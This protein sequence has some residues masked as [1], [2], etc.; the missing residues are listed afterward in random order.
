[1]SDVEFNQAEREI[2]PTKSLAKQIREIGVTKE[3]KW[4]P[5]KIGFRDVTQQEAE[6]AKSFLPKVIL[7]GLSLKSEINSDAWGGILF[8]IAASKDDNERCITYIYNWTKQKGTLSFWFA[9]APALLLSFLALVIL[10]TTNNVLM[11]TTAI[12]VGLFMIIAGLKPYI[13]AIVTKRERVL[14]IHNE[15]WLIFYGVIFIVTIPLEWNVHIIYGGVPAMPF[16]FLAIGLL[17]LFLRLFE[18][19]L[20]LGT[21]EMD[22]EPVFVYL[23]REGE[24]WVISK[25][26]F[27]RFHYIVQTT[28]REELI[29]NNYLIKTKDGERVQ[30]IIDNNWHS[31]RLTNKDYHTLTSMALVIFYIFLGDFIILAISFLFGS[32]FSV[33]ALLIGEAA[34][35]VDPL[36]FWVSGLLYYAIH[37]FELELKDFDPHHPKYHL[38]DRKLDVLWNLNEEE[39]RLIMR[40]KIQDPFNK[41]TLFWSTFRDDALSVLLF[42]VL[43]RLDKIEDYLKKHSDGKYE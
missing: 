22:Y 24:K 3:E 19:K 33:V 5:K 23:K 12:T 29:K 40:L 8:R 27:D 25:V 4:R 13:Q 37:P 2:W 36:V 41:E 26:R 30:L 42:N 1:M 9:V 21:H 17:I 34:I 43:P 15:T 39:A 16:V 20:G 38:T 11:L 32:L 6:L 18:E 14:L 31:M 28:K 10:Y 7:A 35:L